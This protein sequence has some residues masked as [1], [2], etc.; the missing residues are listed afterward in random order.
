LD[1]QRARWRGGE[2]V[3]VEDY[4]ERH[5]GLRDDPDGV[6]ELLYGEILLREER[7]ESPGLEEYQRR[8]PHLAAQLRDQFEVHQALE[9]RR[10]FADA[11]T[12]PPRPSSAG[13]AEQPSIPGYE[14]LAELGRGG[15]GV[16]FKARQIG[17]GRLVAL[18]MIRDSQLASAADR[19]RLRAEAEAVACLDHPNI[20]PIYEVGDWQGQPYFSMKLVEGGSLAEQLPRMAQDPRAALAL[21]ARV[22]RAVHY[23]HQRGFLHRDLKPGNILLDPAGQPHVTDF[24][25]ARRVDGGSGLTQT[26]AVVGTPSYMAPEQAAGTKGLTTAADVYS[27]GA[28]LYE[29][30]TGR[31]PFQA[32]SALDTLLK[33]LDREPEPPRAVNPAADRDLELICL[34][35]LAR[36][37]HERYGSAEALAVDLEHWLAGEP[38]SVRPPALASLARLW[39][40]QNFGAAGWTVALGLAWGV[41]FGAFFWLNRI[42]L[43]VEDHTTAAYARLPGLHPPLLARTRQLPLWV[44]VV[45]AL[46]MLLST[47]VLGLLVA[48][49]ARP[50]NRAAE[51]AAGTFTGLV[52]AVTSF[53]FGVGWSFVVLATVHPAARPDSDLRLLAEPGGGERLLQKYPDLR[54]LPPEKRGGVLYHKVLADWT[55]ELAG[56]IWLGMFWAL[57]LSLTFSLGETL[58][59]SALLR[60]RGSVRAMLLPYAELIAPGFVLVLLCY[61]LVLTVWFSMTPR[62]PW[63]VALL[64]VAVVLLPLAVTAVWRGWHWGL[65]L[66]LHAGWF[67]SMVVA[68]V[69]W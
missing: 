64:V 36:D 1:E 9:S 30:L 6:L 43:L 14:V 44:S 24:G 39:L 4:L 40:R 41:L 50:K 47:C 12:L 63:V 51:I 57:G 55:A 42:N 19:Q 23:A 61:G 46:G 45:T 16:V 54:A 25:L 10:L 65:R 59:A 68:R 56:G 38:L 29:V 32:E 62:Q 34:K 13:P 49:L 8:F 58:A 15:M 35:C 20:V 60:R 17:L 5:P 28:I 22:A 66:P 7:G 31:P 3:P 69:Y 33:V 18:K 11:A 37:P 2:R 27:L 52:A 53:A 26:G 48:V 21:L 67:A